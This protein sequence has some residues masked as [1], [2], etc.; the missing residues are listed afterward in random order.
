MRVVTQKW[1]SMLK[2]DGCDP[3]IIRWDGSAMGFE[4]KS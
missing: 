1:K 3:K 2:N 4:L